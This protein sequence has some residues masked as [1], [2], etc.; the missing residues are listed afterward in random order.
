MKLMTE[1][2]VQ[3]FIKELQDL[4]DSEPEPPE[5]EVDDEIDPEGENLVVFLTKKRKD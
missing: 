1:E 2:E 5:E 3:Q 4:V